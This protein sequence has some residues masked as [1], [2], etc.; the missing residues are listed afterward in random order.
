MRT[1]Q[2]MHNIF[3][4]IRKLCLCVSVHLSLSIEV[5]LI[6]W[7]VLYFGCILCNLF[8]VYVCIYYVLG[9]SLFDLCGF[10]YEYTCV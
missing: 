3:I 1:I 5:I 10:E 9:V 4:L 7:N 6:L 8:F 2:C